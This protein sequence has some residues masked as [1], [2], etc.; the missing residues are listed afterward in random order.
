MEERVFLVGLILYL[1]AVFPAFKKAG[2]IELA[3]FFPDLA[4]CGV[5]FFGKFAQV[6]ILLGIKEEAHQDLDAGF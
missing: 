2:V 3:K 6:C 1:P 4:G 5:K